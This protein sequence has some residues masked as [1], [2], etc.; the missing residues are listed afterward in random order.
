VASVGRLGGCLD[1]WQN[2]RPYYLPRL[3][4]ITATKGTGPF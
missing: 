4:V 1:Y 3:S 2:R